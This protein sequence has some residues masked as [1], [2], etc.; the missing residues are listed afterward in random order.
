MNAVNS[1][2]PYVEGLINAEVVRGD[3]F[4]AVRLQGS[5]LIYGRVSIDSNTV[6]QCICS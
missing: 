4:T 1:L 3:K 6:G 5:N 2:K